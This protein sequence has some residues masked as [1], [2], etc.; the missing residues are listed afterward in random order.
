MQNKT[1]RKFKAIFTLMVEENKEIK[2]QISKLTNALAIQEHGKLPSQAQSILV[3]QY[4]AQTS[5]SNAQ[6]IKE[7]NAIMNRSSIIQGE[8]PSTT[9][10]VATPQKELLAKEVKKSIPVD[11]QNNFEKLKD[12]LQDSNYESS[13]PVEFTNVSAI[14]KSSQDSGTRFWKPRFEELPKE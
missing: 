8:P 13:G 9:T 11:L 5:S 12:L 4:M 6:N 7:V 1:N 14:S 3:G 2:S 10:N